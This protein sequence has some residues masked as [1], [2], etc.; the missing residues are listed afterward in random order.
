MRRTILALVAF[1]VAMAST[2]VFAGGYCNTFVNSAVAYNNN[3]AVAVAGAP[4][5]SNVLVQPTYVASVPV[6]VQAVTAANTAV[7]VQSAPAV[8]YSKVAVA[9]L[10]VANYGYN[11]VAVQAVANGYANVGV[12]N[13]R[14]RNVHGHGGVAVQAKAF[15]GR[16]VVVNGGGVSIASANNGV[17]V[18]ANGNQRASVRSRT[19]ILGQNVTTVRAK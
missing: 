3:V 12:Q 13:V 16:N 7:V 5:Y 18:A 2:S 1:A 9:P 11:N 8:L 15:G 14:V 19:G 10:A 17:S 4:V 6:A